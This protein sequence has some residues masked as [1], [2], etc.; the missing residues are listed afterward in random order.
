MSDVTVTLTDLERDIV[1]D[2]LESYEEAQATGTN[3]GGIIA[4]L[5]AAAP[6]APTEWQPVEAYVPIYSADSPPH[7]GC[8]VLQGSD[9]DVAS[10]LL[11][12]GHDDE[13]HALASVFLPAD[14]RLCRRAPAA[15]SPL[16]RLHT[17]LA[18]TRPGLF[19][20]LSGNNDD[21]AGQFGGCSIWD[22][23]DE[24]YIAHGHGETLAA[25]V[26]AALA[27]VEGGAE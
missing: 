11:N 5:R 4:K 23:V 8:Y 7:S 18:D 24:V 27:Q 21:E 6:A 3:L 10:G 25:A 26:E 22:D 20:H 19:A 15:P 1:I 13:D 9:N 12:I 14:V 16:D 2:A 17:Y